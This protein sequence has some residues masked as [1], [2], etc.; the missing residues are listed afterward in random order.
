MKDR[1]PRVGAGVH[2]DPVAGLGEAPLVGESPGQEAKPTEKRVIVG[3]QI[4]EAREVPAWNEEQV[5]G[6]LG[7]D[8]FEG[9]KLLVGEHNFCR[10]CSDGNP[11]E[12]ALVHPRNLALQ[13]VD[14]KK[15]RCR[16]FWYHCRPMLI[17]SKSCPEG[18]RT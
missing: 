9:H 18:I 11:T 1:L 3:R 5:N 7:L 16:N 12:E 15:N 14:S 8:I 4:V 6:S 2:H 17:D 13:R 10:N